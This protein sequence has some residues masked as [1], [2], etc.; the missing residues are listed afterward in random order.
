[1][2]KEERRTIGQRA[3]SFLTGIFASAALVQTAAAGIPPAPKAPPATE[4]SCVQN[5]DDDDTLYSDLHDLSR[6]SAY[7]IFMNEQGLDPEAIHAIL[8]ASEETG[9]DFDLMIVKAILESDLGRFNAP[10]GVNG[11]ARGMYQF[12]PTT[13]LTVFAWYGERYKDGQYADL[14]RAIRF[15][16]NGNPYVNDPQVK[17]EILDLRSDHYIASYIK[18]MQVK[19]DERPNLRNMLGHEPTFTDYYI[20]HFLGIPRARVFYRNLQNNPDGAAANVLSREARYNRSVFYR[21]NQ[22][23]SFAD[24]YN[25]LERIIE[26]RLA[27]FDAVSEDV[28]KTQGCVKPLERNK[29]PLLPGH[30]GFYI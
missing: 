7:A 4:R 19:Y 22:P 13:W 27:G 18:A 9:V 12:L 29:P 5:I 30:P 23:R 11:G 16:G 28:L 10:I 15:D 21:G 14:A 26:S 24:V 2:A 3:A 8:E 20:V 17:Q 25:R 6:A 1:M